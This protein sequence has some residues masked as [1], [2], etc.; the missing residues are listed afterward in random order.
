MLARWV[1]DL[2]GKIPL[3]LQDDYVVIMTFW[4]DLFICLLM[5]LTKYFDEM[6]TET[7]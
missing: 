1:S 6:F 7:L 4:D 2:D 3:K 5:L